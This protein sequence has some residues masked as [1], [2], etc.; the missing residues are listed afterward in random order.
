MAT[1]LVGRG[2]EVGFLRGLTAT[3]PTSSAAVLVRGE[4]GI[5]KTLLVETVLEGTTSPQRPST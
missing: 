2:D 1:E 4:A 3:L 5:G